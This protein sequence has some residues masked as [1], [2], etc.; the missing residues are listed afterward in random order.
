[1][2]QRSLRAVAHLLG[3]RMNYQDGKPRTIEVAIYLQGNY[4]PCGRIIFNSTAN[5]AAFEYLPE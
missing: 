4:V 3:T 1:M 5:A 2:N